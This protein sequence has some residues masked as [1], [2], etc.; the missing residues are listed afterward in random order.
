MPD[1]FQQPFDMGAAQQLMPTEG[2]PIR[3]PEEQK[4]AEMVIKLYEKG[5]KAREKYDKD[6]QKYAD[7]YKGKQWPD[8]RPSYKASPVANII[9]QSVQ[10]ILPILTDAQPGFNVEPR[11]PDDYDFADFF[12]SIVPNWWTRRGMN[13]TLLDPLMDMMIYGIGYLKVVWD[14]EAEEGAGDVV[15]GGVAPEM[16]YFPEGAKSFD[17]GCPWVVQEIWKPLGEI[18]R[19]FPDR[20]E[21]IVSS[22]KQE[23][24][25]MSSSNSD[26]TLISPIDRKSNVPVSGSSSGSDS[27]VVCIL[28]AWMDDYSIEEFEDGEGNKKQKLKYPGGKV[29]KVLRDQKILLESIAN[30]RK[31]GKKPYVRFIDTVE[32][33]SFVGEGEVAPLLEIQKLI[34]KSLAHI[35]D[36]MNMFGNPVWIIDT[37][38]GVS[39]ADITN[40]IGLIITKNPNTEVRRDM[41][42]SLPPYVI[43]FYNMM[44]S[45]AEMI[46]GVHD[47]TQGR[48]PEG[49]T[50]A[51]AINDLQEAAQTRIRLKERN[52]QVSLTSLGYLTTATMMQYYKEPRVVK[53][54]GKQGWPEFF[55]FY[56]KDTE[57]GKMYYTKRGYKFDENNRRYVADENWTK[58]Q[59]SKGIFDI[60]VVAGTSLPFMKGKRQK[61]AFDLFDRKVIDAEELLESQ[62]YPRREQIMKRMLEQGA[63]APPAPEGN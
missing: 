57:D 39:P 42:P 8:K 40:Q 61:L 44:L 63:G 48:K 32:P 21:L 14:P 35:V 38:S 60:D 9:R 17:D 37:N 47:V 36:Y 34:N 11:E 20:A 50:A 53:V 26:A 3:D 19:K 58:G 45:M 12:G 30:P 29:I 25:V 1:T 49:I 46:N 54:T 18:K 27:E 55:E 31:D 15:C 62:E 7:N 6:W 10:T 13:L 5:K 33:R 52:L 28:E 51:A 24:E 22:G 4:E 41:P 2:G 16:L 23:A 43:D 56:L 59:P